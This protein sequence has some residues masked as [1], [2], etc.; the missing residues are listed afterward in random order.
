MA[1]LPLSPVGRSVCACGRFGS[2]RG[3]GLQEAAVCRDA[4]TLVELL[5]VLLIMSVLA[6][7][8]VVNLHGR[9]DD[10]AMKAIVR[11]FATALRTAAASAHADARPFRVAMTEQRDG[12]RIETL[13]ADG[14]TYV[15]VAGQAGIVRPWPRG[16]SVSAVP[17]PTQSAGRPTVLENGLLALG[18]DAVQEFV[19]T[20]DGEGFTGVITVQGPAGTSM[21]IEVIGPLGQVHVLD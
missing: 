15:A 14:S 1:L 8:C 2:R 3:V 10:V 13:S 4:F 21:R 12:F 6:A 9:Q 5:L 17:R 19:F 20:P 18:A 11:D 7:A 16:V